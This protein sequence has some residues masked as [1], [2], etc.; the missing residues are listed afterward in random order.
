ME[1]LSGGKFLKCGLERELERVMRG[2]GV[3][4]RCVPGF[5]APLHGE[6]AAAVAAHDHRFRDPPTLSEGRRRTRNSDEWGF[7]VERC[8]EMGEGW[9]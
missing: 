2:D 1:S 5:P 6:P 9:G 3:V 4:T 8:V 7:P